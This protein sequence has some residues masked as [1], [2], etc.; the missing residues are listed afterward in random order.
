MNN[1]F[2]NE[3]NENTEEQTVE[4]I[5]DGIELTDTTETPAVEETIEVKAKLYD[6]DDLDKILARKMARR[7]AKL[8]KEFEQKLSKYKNTEEILKVGLGT[9]DIDETNSQ[10]TDYY[11]AQGLTLPE[12][13]K[14]GLSDKEI[15]ILARAEAEDIIEDG[16]EEMTKEA[17]LLANKGYANLTIKER[18][19]F[20]TLAGKLDFENK[21]KELSKIGVTTDILEDKGFKE[22][23]NK[24]SIKTD[25]KEVYEL[26]SRKEPAKVVKPIGSMVSIETNKVKDFYT[27]D[28]MKS[29]T[30][31][32]YD[33]PQIMKAVELS[34]EKLYKDN[35]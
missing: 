20:N 16:I 21:K 6:D 14:Q 8:Q 27:Y 19:I 33:N 28:E 1:E 24:F 5:V 35:H 12:Q 11:K 22:F 25:I 29:L 30:Q 34:L 26:Y 13:V 4:E 23:A 7:E 9:K 17:N 32:D 31:K 2:V 18:V 15:E 10:L 3:L